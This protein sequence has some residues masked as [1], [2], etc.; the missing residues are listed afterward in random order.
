[1]TPQ[2]KPMSRQSALTKSEKQKLTENIK[3]SMET[4]NPSRPKLS[5]EEQRWIREATNAGC[6]ELYNL[7]SLFAYTAIKTHYEN[8]ARRYLDRNR[9]EMED[10]MNELYVTVHTNIAR[11]DG[12]HS[13]F[14][15]FDPLVNSSFMVARNVGRGGMMTKY[16]HDVGVTITRARR[17]LAAKGFS[18]PSILDV[19]DY[20][21][22]HYDQSIS[23]STIE[24]YGTY[25]QDVEYLD[26]NE[27]MQ[28]CPED[29]PEKQV[30][31][32]EEKQ[33]FHQ[34]L[35]KLSPRHRLFVIKELEYINLHGDMPTPE[36]VL[37]L[38]HEDGYDM[39]LHEATQ[40][41]RASH[42]ELRGLLTK[43]KRKEAPV[44]YML[45]L[46][47]DYSILEEE[48]QNVIDAMANGDIDLIIPKHKPKN[49]F[50]GKAEILDEIDLDKRIDD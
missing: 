3:K 13:L 39:T 48:E 20:I 12:V 5:P 25:S 8:T 44:N 40:I 50:V 31:E 33:E 47:R 7:G 15:F 36:E 41:Q 43:K 14:T 16:Y 30:I 22:L 18:E 38:I 28:A 35:A 23:E 29:D 17:E 19:R 45:T 21:K 6:P 34:N 42:I 49:A 27:R 1:M 4:F 32:N 10:L 9:T 26:A 2:R 11:Y 46:E 37:A 24:R